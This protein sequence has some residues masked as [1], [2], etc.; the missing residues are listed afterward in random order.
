MIGD[1]RAVEKR[2]IVRAVVDAPE[3]LV[4]IVRMELD[5]AVSAEQRSADSSADVEIEAGSLPPVGRLADET[6][7][8]EPRRN[9]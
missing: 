7:D 8:A 6:W 3:R 5:P 4:G 1:V 9:G 2:K